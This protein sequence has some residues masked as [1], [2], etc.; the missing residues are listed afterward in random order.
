MANHLSKIHDNLTWSRK[1]LYNVLTKNRAKSF[2]GDSGGRGSLQAQEKWKADDIHSFYSWIAESTHAKE[3]QPIP[4]L[5]CNLIGMGCDDDLGWK[6][7][8]KVLKR[9]GFE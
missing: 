6:D 8:Q 9:A 3:V 5:N 2:W 4:D 1:D 7:Y